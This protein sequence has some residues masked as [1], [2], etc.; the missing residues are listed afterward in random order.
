VNDSVDFNDML[1][2]D[3]EDA[4]RAAFDRNR[5]PF[6][7]KSRAAWPILNPAAWEGRPVPPREWIVKDF[8]PARTVTLLSGEGAAGKSTLALQL[9]AARSLGKAWLST[10]PKA[11]RTLVLSA[12]DEEDEL[13]RRLDAIRQHYGAT[14]PC[15]WRRTGCRLASPLTRWQR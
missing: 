10:I 1:R 9:A 13:H 11:G 2:R 8:I 14:W 15:S 3:G 4:V 5:R 7:T 12:E 6:R